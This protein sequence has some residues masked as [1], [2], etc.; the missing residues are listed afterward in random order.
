MPRRL[1]ID[2][3]AE[4]VT[5]LH[6]AAAQWLAEHDGERIAAE[7]AAT[8]A[9]HRLPDPPAR[10]NR[11]KFLQGPPAIRN[12]MIES[13]SRRRAAISIRAGQFAT[14]QS[15]PCTSG[16]LENLIKITGWGR[17]GGHS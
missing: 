9:A 5:R 7:L 14:A 12:A 16:T 4:R 15:H 10:A 6:D 17:S 1:R 8:R 11:R 3:R 13:A 2:S